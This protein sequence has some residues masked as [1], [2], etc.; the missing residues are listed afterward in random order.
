[1]GCTANWRS[2]PFGYLFHF[3]VQASSGS[4]SVI[5]GV[6]I[7][8]EIAGVG[9]QGSRETTTEMYRHFQGHF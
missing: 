5:F 3:L 6:L 7:A 4:S 1:L 8:E 9:D 2:I